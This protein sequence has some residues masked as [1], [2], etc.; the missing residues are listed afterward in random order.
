LFT[1]T[2]ENRVHIFLRSAHTSAF[3]QKTGRELYVMV[4]DLSSTKPNFI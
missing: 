3:I 1:T 2:L 4:C